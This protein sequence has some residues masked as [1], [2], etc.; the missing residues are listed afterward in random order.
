MLSTRATSSAVSGMEKVNLSPN[1]S[2]VKRGFTKRQPME[3]SKVSP[4]LAKAVVGLA[5]TQGARDMD[6]TPPATTMSAAPALIMKVAMAMALMPE[7]HSRFTVIP[8]TV[9]GKPASSQAM[10]ATLRFSSPA[11]FA[12]PRIT[13]STSAGSIPASVTTCFTTRAARSSGRTED[14]APP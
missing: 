13:S 7:A 5:V 8:G 4:G 12:L 6:S 10:R 2:L 9:S 14:R 11:P 3:V 1:S